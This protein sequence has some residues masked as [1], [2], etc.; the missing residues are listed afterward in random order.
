ME[1]MEKERVSLT[2]VQELPLFIE[3]VLVLGLDKQE[4]CFSLYKNGIHI[5]KRA[6]APSSLPALPSLVANFELEARLMCY[7]M[8]QR[9]LL[10]ALC[11]SIC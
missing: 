9:E 4:C 2:T 1:K 3:Q 8:D 7:F 6:H 5:P 10:R 11:M